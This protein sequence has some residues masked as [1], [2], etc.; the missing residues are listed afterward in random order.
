MLFSSYEF[1]LFLPIVFCLYWLLNRYKLIAQNSLL[2]VAGYFFYG[3]WSWKFMLLLFLSTLLDFLYGFGV[4]SANR[5]KAKF[6]LWLSIINNLGILAI[7]KYYNFFASECSHLLQT[8]GWQ[9]NLPILEIIL[10]VGI[11]FYTFHG[12]SYVF[13]IYR[14]KQRPISNFV[15]YA[16]F[17]SFF[18]LL[19]AGPIERAQHLLPQIQTKRQFDYMQAV[20]GCRLILWGLFKKIVIADSLAEFVNRIYANYNNE[21]GLSLGLGALAFSFQIYGDFSGYSDIALGTARLFGFELLSN[22][23]FPYFSRD[24]AEFWRRWHISLSSWFRDYVY[25][26]LGGSRSGKAK[27]IRNTF[28]IFL[29][30]GFWHGASWNYVF[31][32]LIHALAFI[33]LLIRNR[34][35]IHASDV[36]AQHHFLPSPKE[37]MQ[38]LTTF[39]V[40]TIAWIFFRMQHIADA[41]AYIKRF[42]SETWYHPNDYFSD[43]KDW[44]ILT[45]IL[46]LLILDWR[47]RRNERDLWVPTNSVLR[48][49]IYVVMIWSLLSFNK[50]FENAIRI[51]FI[52]FQF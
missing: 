21:T 14:E 9:I 16:V 39:C 47:L 15:D 32:G 31:W 50:M 22:F 18:P 40:V 26:P 37:L 45:F 42:L 13:D 44:R 1:I 4:A 7:F 38:M 25:I 30:S 28:I 10:P 11:S 35:R 23:R 43:T 2:L 51:D 49:A 29:L 46:P 27:A 48:I 41:F 12:M 36:A 17:V 6:Y 8:I 5:S 24:I 20:K 52:Y 34:N 3:W 33:P 19:V